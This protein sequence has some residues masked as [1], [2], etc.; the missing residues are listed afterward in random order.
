MDASTF[1]RRYRAVFISD[2]H[3][4]SRGC[5]A[6]LLLD[7]LR[8][9]EC[10]QL[11]LV[12]D[13]I[14][15]WKL[16]SGWYWPQSHNDVVQK[17]LRKSRKGTTVTYI[18]GNHDEFA[19]GYFGAHFGG[20]QVV[21]EAVHTTADGRRYLV[22]HGDAYDGVV[23]KARWLAVLGDWA[24]RALL[25]A[26]TGWNRLRRRLG[27]GYWS[28]AAYLK[29]KVKTATKFVDDFERALAD[30][31]QRRGFDGVICGHIHKAEMRDIDGVEYINDGDWVESCTAL[32]EHA[33]GRLELLDWGK[34]R[35][36]S[37]L[38]RSGPDA[39]TE[40]PASMP[41]PVGGLPAF[42]RALLG[43]AAS[44]VQVGR[45]VIEPR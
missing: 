39:V 23:S 7:F 4:G 19:R 43:G 16:K 25:R 14:D 11:Y 42:A 27:M 38:D 3:L 35:D 26:N 18:P 33:D 29:A 9:V 2:I 31:A 12:G 6:E 41:V 34:I 28:F 24:Y 45:T 21:K 10:E 44:G 36:W 40:R 13:I 37:M 15:G 17:L 22:V 32:V 1:S 20:V 8:E 30:E 5:Q